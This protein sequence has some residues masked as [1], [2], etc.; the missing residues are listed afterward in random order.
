MD[1][2]NLVLTLAVSPVSFFPFSML[3]ASLNRALCPIIYSYADQVQRD[4]FN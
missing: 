1:M 2:Q 4:D 3:M